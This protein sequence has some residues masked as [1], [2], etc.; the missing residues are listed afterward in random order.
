MLGPR[1][2]PLTI[3]VFRSPRRPVSSPTGRMSQS[4]CRRR[5]AVHFRMPFRGVGHFS[6]QRTAVFSWDSPPRP[7]LSV[8]P[9]AFRYSRATS[10]F[11]Q[12][13]LKTITRVGSS[14]SS[15]EW[16]TRKPDALIMGFISTEQEVVSRG[17]GGKRRQSPPSACIQSYWTKRNIRTMPLT[18]AVTYRLK[19]TRSECG[20]LGRGSMVPRARW[21]PIAPRCVSCCLTCTRAKARQ[22]PLCS[23][24]IGLGGLG[25]VTLLLIRIEFVINQPSK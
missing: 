4:A 19:T 13:L 20:K 25:G 18:S 23:Q 9:N 6:L 21:R 8:L 3:P 11:R 12:S 15:T 10:K 16:S 14:W 2:S 24:F 7:I 5:G 17:V 1:S 22:E